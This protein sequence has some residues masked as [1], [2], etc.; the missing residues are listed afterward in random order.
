[1]Q[2]HDSKPRFLYE[3]STTKKKSQTFFAVF[4]FK[5]K[6]IRTTIYFNIHT[7][8]IKEL[9]FT[10]IVIDKNNEDSCGF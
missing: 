10:F 6:K 9:L 5:I 1:M 4:S 3:N 8:T 2:Q 7:S